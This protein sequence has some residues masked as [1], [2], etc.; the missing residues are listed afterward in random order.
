MT[1]PAERRSPVHDL[2]ASRA[3]QWGR[4]GDTQVALRFGPAEEEAAAV[5]T[6]ALADASALPKLGVKGPGAEAW[7]R[8]QE[9]EVPPATYDTRPL[10]GGGLIA[11]LGAGDFFLEGG[12]A[13]GLLP[14]LRERLAGALG[15]YPVERQDATFLLAG[16]RAPEVL[17]QVCSIDFA[18]APPRRL[19]LTRSAGVN[20]GVL[21]E[22]RDEL[23]VFRL[24]VDYTYAASFWESLAEIAEEVGGRVVGAACFYPGLLEP[25]G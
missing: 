9:V 23:A 3:A 24:W 8:G 17:A 14:R 11:R 19:I 25:A 18:T 16:S 7:L 10:A 12:P 6:L 4:L 1:D 22:P 20:C 2:L 15:V 5:R 13:G 21:P